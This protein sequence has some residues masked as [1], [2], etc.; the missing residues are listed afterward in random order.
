MGGV[1]GVVSPLGQWGECVAS[2]W[3]ME[4][5]GNAGSVDLFTQFAEGIQC[6]LNVLVRVRRSDLS[7]E[8]RVRFTQEANASAGLE[9]GAAER[10]ASDAQRLPGRALDLYQGGDV[11]DAGNRDLVRAFV[12]SLP[13]GEEGAVVTKGGELSLAGAQRLRNALL[14]RAY[15]DA[16][17]VGSLAEVGDDSIRAFGRVL[18]D[19]APAVAQLREGIGSGAVAAGADLIGEDTVAGFC[20]PPCGVRVCKMYGLVVWKHRE[21]SAHDGGFSG[22]ARFG[23]DKPRRSFTDVRQQPCGAVDGD[24]FFFYEVDDG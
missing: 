3:A 9:L 14:H 10:A 1:C 22:A 15:G 6:L 8:D 24:G 11:T 18:Q 19:L 7:P 17:L 21:K 2:S 13:K 20:V 16:N 12:A 23:A 5:S 4:N